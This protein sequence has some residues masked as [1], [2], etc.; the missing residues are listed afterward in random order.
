MI[1]F[2]HYGYLDLLHLD[3]HVL[4]QLQMRLDRLGVDVLTSLE[5]T[6][7]NQNCIL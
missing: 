3:K 4:S 2:S 1:K 5:I 6:K 7:T